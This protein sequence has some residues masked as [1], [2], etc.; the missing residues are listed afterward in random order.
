[1]N[2]RIPGTKRPRH[3]GQRAARTD[4][5]DEAVDLAI[6]LLPDLGAGRFQMKVTVGKIFE[7]IGPPGAMRFRF[8][9]RFREPPGGMHKMIGVLVRHGRNQ[10]HF[11]AISSQRRNFLAALVI[12]HDD[13]GAMPKGAADHGESDAGIARGALHNDTA[14]LQCSCL[15]RVE[16]HA[17]CC[18]VL[19][20]TTRIHELGFAEDLTARCVR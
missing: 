12:G 18:P 5:T 7:L 6:R 14:R 11:G 4:R 15:F 19:D 13:D 3:A 10:L 16:N 2:V 9:E 1:M 17:E 8:V 20:R